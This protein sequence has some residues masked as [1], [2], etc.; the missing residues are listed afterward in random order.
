MRPTTSRICKTVTESRVSNLYGIFISYT[1]VPL[2]TIFADVKHCQEQQVKMNGTFDFPQ[3][4]NKTGCYEIEKSNTYLNMALM[5]YRLGLFWYDYRLSIWTA[6]VLSFHAVNYS[7]SYCHTLLQLHQGHLSSRM[8]ADTYPSLAKRFDAWSYFLV[9]T[10]EGS[11]SR[12]YAV[13]RVVHY[14]PS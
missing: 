11:Y 9:D 10:Y 6:L 12:P 14:Q 3:I 1:S 8:A 13:D 4:P 2:W 7:I 5:H